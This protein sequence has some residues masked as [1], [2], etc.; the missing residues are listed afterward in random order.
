MPLVYG[1]GLGGSGTT[2]AF[3]SRPNT[4]RIAPFHT[5]GATRRAAAKF[6]TVSFIHN[7]VVRRY[8]EDHD[9]RVRDPPYP[10]RW[11]QTSVNN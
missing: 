6:V 5:R 8:V 4:G 9:G 10:G 2:S 3:I 7:R 11:R 1:P